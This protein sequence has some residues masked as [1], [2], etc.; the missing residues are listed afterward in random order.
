MKPVLA[1]CTLIVWV[2]GAVADMPSSSTDGVQVSAAR[3]VSFKKG[4]CWPPSHYAQKNYFGRYVFTLANG[5]I[6]KCAGDDQQKKFYKPPAPYVERAEISG[7]N[8]TRGQR[9]LFSTGVHFDPA[10]A[11]SNQTTFFT[12]HQWD[13][14]TCRCSPYVRLVLDQG[15]RL[16]AQVLKRPGKTETYRLG[17]WDRDDFETQWVEV[18]IDIDTSATQSLSI[19]IGGQHELTTNVLVQEGAS[20]FPKIGLL[21]PGTTRT[22]LPTDRVHFQDVKFA[23]LKR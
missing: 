10:F 5:D 7:H 23:R 14:K 16:F 1:L 13:S 20:V 2:S 3:P 18:A 22:R 17:N 15:G 9:Y 21:R 8:Q 12:V 6:G 11:S 19:Y 4:G